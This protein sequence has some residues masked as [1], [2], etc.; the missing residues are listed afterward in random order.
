MFSSLSLPTLEIY[1]LLVRDKETTLN[2]FGRVG[3]EQR[4]QFKILKK[5]RAKL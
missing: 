4:V 1:S 5:Q 3:Q 2:N